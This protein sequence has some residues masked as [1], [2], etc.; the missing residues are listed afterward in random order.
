MI[1]RNRFPQE[2]GV[3]GLSTTGQRAEPPE[4]FGWIDS[5][6]FGRLPPSKSPMTAVRRKKGSTFRGLS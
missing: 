3:V 4:P 2:E 1:L 6:F 5:K